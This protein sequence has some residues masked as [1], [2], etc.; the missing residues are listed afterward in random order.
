MI[1]I[2]DLL[3]LPTVRVQLQPVAQI[4]ALNNAFL[5]T[6]CTLK[7]VEETEWDVIFYFLWSK[8]KYSLIENVFKI[9]LKYRE[10]GICILSNL[11]S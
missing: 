4:T 2:I 8:Y 3:V 6:K 5:W 10:P 9:E 1:L 7:I 11:V